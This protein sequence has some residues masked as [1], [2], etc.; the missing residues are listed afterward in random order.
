MSE[1]ISRQ[2]AIGE[3]LIP[4]ARVGQNL[5]LSEI[6]SLP[7]ALEL[8]YTAL[9]M[10]VTSQH[11]ALFIARRFAERMGLNAKE[12]EAFANYRLEEVMRYE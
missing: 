11:P 2:K 10:K 7:I 1:E 9:S 4:E 12:V 3:V 6:D 5:L 8:F